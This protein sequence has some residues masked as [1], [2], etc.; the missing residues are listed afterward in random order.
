MQKIKISRSDL[1]MTF[2]QFSEGEMTAYL[3]TADGSI[4]WFDDLTIRRLDTLLTDEETLEQVE[5]TLQAQTNRSES[6]CKQL[7]ETARIE[8]DADNRYR[9]VPHQNSYEGY[10]DMQEFIWS[11]EDERLRELL[12]VAIRGSGAFG[13]FKDVIHRDSTARDK[14]Y[15]FR[16]ARQHERI[17]AWLRREGFEPEVV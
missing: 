2:E 1:E 7:L 11:L 3:D 6:E 9:V 15:L 10:R 12:E 17:L 5:A 8:W 13:R 16:D 14:W 4:T